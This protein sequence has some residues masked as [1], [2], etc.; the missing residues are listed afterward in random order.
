M[1]T[2]IIIPAIGLA[3]A[4]FGATASATIF[5]MGNTHGSPMNITYSEGNTSMQSVY[6]AGGNFG[7]TT[8]QA[9]LDSVS[10]AYVYC[11]DLFDDINLNTSYTATVTFNG[12]VAETPAHA[13]GNADANGLINNAAAIAWLINSHAS[14]ATNGD[15]QSGLQAAIWTEI[16]GTMGGSGPNSWNIVGI[17]SSIQ[18]AMTADLAGLASASDFIN[19]H[20]TGLISSVYWIDPTNGTTQYQQEV[21]ANPIDLGSIAPNQFQITSQSSSAIPEPTSI[22]L[23]GIGIIGFAASHNKKN[24]A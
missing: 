14:L 16:Y 18:A 23:L 19:T 7:A 21:G 12:T 8:G 3:M 15:L 1:K 2:K 17:S 11:I 9:T 24:Q 5:T 13:I 22:A 4:M 10:L 20:S 6:G